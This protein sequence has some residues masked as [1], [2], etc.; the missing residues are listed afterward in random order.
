MDL[1]SVWKRS[2]GKG[3]PA[4]RGAAQGRAGG[5]VA[6]L[7]VLLQ[8]GVPLPASREAFLRRAMDEGLAFFDAYNDVRLELALSSF[9]SDMLQALYEILFL[10]HVNDP[11]LA[12]WRF[13][14][15]RAE[16]KGAP[17]K[18]EPEQTAN[19]FVESAP[20]GV[21]GLERLSARFRDEFRDYV[22]ATFAM[23]L[24][25]PRGTH[26]PFVSV[27]SIGSIGTIGHKRGASDL[28]LQV[29]YSLE[30]FRYD[31]ATL[32]DESVRETMR[33]EL[34]ALMR[35]IV[36]RR[37]VTR[38]QMQSPVAQKMVKGTAM[39]ELA[40]LYPNLHKY[41]I[42]RQGDYRAEF[43]APGGEPLRIQCLHELI[44]L[45]K[46][47]QKL[48]RAQELAQAEAR[49]KERIGLIQGYISRR[50]PD[51]E[52]YLFPMSIDDYRLGKYSSTVEFKESSGSAYELILNHETLM[53]GI[54]FTPV[55]PSH[56]IFPE[57]VNNNLA[58]FTRLSDYT[59]FGS[60]RLYEPIE[61]RLVNLGA[62]PNL[63]PEYLA[64]H[65]GAAYWEA[66]K[67]SSGNLPK[68]TLNLL[69][70]EMLLDPRYL[71]TVIQLVKQPTVLDHL[72]TPKPAPASGAK[73][74]AKEP[75]GLPPWQILEMEESFP[76]LRQEPWWLRYKALK[77]AFAEPGGVEGLEAAERERV[78]RVLDLA[79]ALH[80]RISDVF[81]KPGERRPFETFREQTLVDL[82]LR[83]FPPG[84]A[85]RQRV[86]QIFI[87]EVHAVNEFEAE[88][89]E[90]FKLSLARV[91]AKVAAF[92]LKEDPANR[93][94]F[95]IWH[96]YYQ[97]NFDPK[98][99]M[100]QRSIMHHLKVPRGRLQIG[101][102]PGKG[103][104][105]RSIQRESG[106][107]K[108]FD[109]FGILDHLPDMVT[110]VET[111]NFLEGLTHC[112]VN[113]Y[114]GVMNAGTL[115]EYKTALEFDGT[116]LDLGHPAHNTLAFLRPDHMDRIL[117]LVMEHFPPQKYDYLDVIRQER[118]VTEVLVFLNL[119]HFGRLSIL[120]R[121]NLRA[122]YCQEYDHPELIKQAQTL[123][124]SP[125]AL[126]AW[127]GFQTTL[128]S[129]LD[130]NKVLL[131]E[132]RLSVWVNPN[133]VV[134][135]HS[136]TQTVQK[137]GELARMFG[138]VI[139]E[140]HGG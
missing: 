112:I 14:A 58:L 67:A 80:C 97:D 9:D 140:T 48:A 98:P 118:K 62:A 121:D 78:S 73:R 137:E 55:V 16:R 39:E 120:Y 45:L 52:V 139:Q 108:R 53:P 95:A 66:F 40:K 10:L 36:Q 127:P 92:G 116:R 19:L 12:S 132:A 8:E 94:E 79:F 115:K 7:A 21:Q 26:P 74:A 43:A 32:G 125:A 22:R 23:E 2:P 110:L 114:Y 101:Y 29:V 90:L 30:P 51:S 20:H 91:R 77:I 119:W 18:A 128:G 86:E 103:W 5:E 1:R 33:Q 113:S 4:P 56:F 122:Y 87:G 124:R 13:T 82:L 71:K 76:R 75:E 89:R 60:L 59:R 44:N 135:N 129:F 54:Q 72:A 38:E 34:A 50:F 65:S 61:A 64:R 93:E 69:R 46:R 105:F 41:L 15:R 31:I 106:I 136:P 68:S 131:N 83:A 11:R 99:A 102:D 117:R 138:Q 47:A 6:G 109:T 123:N 24:V 27:H 107:G 111:P 88:L 96:H 100:V 28:D 126:L 49:L 134:T 130:S 70:Y 85:Q 3:P 133:S 84:S 37:G 57:E 35:E 42:R 17:R 63:T 25:P 81:T 104:A